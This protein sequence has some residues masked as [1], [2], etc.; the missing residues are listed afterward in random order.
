MDTSISAFNLSLLKHETF[1]KWVLST[2]PFANFTTQCWKILTC[3]VYLVC[4]NIQHFFPGS[5]LRKKILKK[6]TNLLYLK[7]CICFVENRH[8]NGVMDGVGAHRLIYFIFRLGVQVQI[9]VRCWFMISLLFIFV[10]PNT[11]Y[12]NLYMPWCFTLPSKHSVLL[13]YSVSVIKTIFSYNFTVWSPFFMA[14]QAGWSNLQDIKI[15]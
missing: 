14:N 5:L 12:T 3:N 11:T 8:Q 4:R 13:C 9:L 2:L 1:I 6:C 15:Y 10:Q 7:F